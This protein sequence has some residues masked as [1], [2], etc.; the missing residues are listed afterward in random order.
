VLTDGGLGQG[1]RINEIAADTLV[2]LH[3]AS[4]DADTGRMSQGLAYG[5]QPIRIDPVMG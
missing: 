1:Q 5:G 2:E 3:K 4:H